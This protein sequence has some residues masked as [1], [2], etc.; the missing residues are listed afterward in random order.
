MSTFL[1]LP[2]MIGVLGLTL[3]SVLM[4]RFD[5]ARQVQE[6]QVDFRDID[7]YLKDQMQ[8]LGIPGM[9]IGIVHEDQIVHWQGFGEADS[10]G[11]PVTP[12]TPFQIGSLTKSFTAL[13]VMQLVE[14]GKVDLDAPV[15]KYLPWFTLADKDAA[16]RI[17]VRN[18]L[19]QSSSISTTDGNRFWNS[20]ASMDNAVR[21]MSDVQLRYP[22]GTKYQY[23]NMNYVILGVVIEK[24]SGESY[25]DYVNE[26]I[27]IP[28]DMRNSYTSHEDALA[29]GLAEGHYYILDHAVTRDGVYP[30]AYLSTGLLSASVEDLTHYAIAQLNEGKYGEQTILSKDRMTELHTPGIS[31]GAGDYHYA[32]GW[33]VG[34]TDGIH[35]IKHNG[36]I[37]SYH[38][39][40]MLEP[41]SKWGVVLLAN[42]SGFEQIM[43]ID[44]MAEGVME[45]LNNKQPARVSLPFMFRLLYWG[46]LL[47]PLLQLVGIVRGLLHVQSGLVIQPWGVV[48]TVVLNLVVAF[49]YL[50]KI[51]GLVPFPLS[52]LLVFYPELGY[53][54]I[55]SA[56]LGFGWSTAYPVLRWI[57]LIR[58]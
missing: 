52:S 27:L 12:Q 22:V 51:P 8:Q 43:Q 35:I 15:Q 24:V 58:S 54:L 7:L 10:T 55:A 36:D 18:L 39:I 53:G 46:V 1:N 28:L 33:A 40:V 4:F 9:A 30:P 5:N 56:F 17:T 50:F 21:Q 49:L 41:E 48:V 6:T 47:T 37:I 26:H 32:M 25:A 11:R 19:N 14:D 20:N 13:A 57:Q 2:S 34:T 23:C 45:L 38:S 42:A 16:A 44:D 3:M 29:N 31:M